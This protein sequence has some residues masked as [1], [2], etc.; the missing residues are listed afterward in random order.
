MLSLSILRQDKAYALVEFLDTYELAQGLLAL[1]VSARAAGHPSYQG[2]QHSIA[3]VRVSELR[4]EREILKQEIE[5]WEQRKA[6]CCARLPRLALLTPCQQL[7][8]VEAVD[9][10]RDGMPAALSR[11]VPP[12]VRT[13]SRACVRLSDCSLLIF[14][15]RTCVHV[16]VSCAEPRV[17]R[18]WLRAVH[19]SGRLP[20]CPWPP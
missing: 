6:A 4:V 17:Q 1:V 10:V 8:L 19:V 18:M 15:P 12:A 7:D 3:G 11:L 16:L 9:A 20:T 14:L 5:A 13:K 2:S